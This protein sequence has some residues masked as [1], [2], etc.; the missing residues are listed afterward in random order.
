MAFGSA[1]GL[2]VSPSVKVFPARFSIPLPSPYTR[3]PEVQVAVPAFWS[4]RLP[5]SL[6]P[7]FRV[8]LPLTRRKYGLSNRVSA[9]TSPP[10]MVRV[11]TNAVV[12]TPSGLSKVTP[13]PVTSRLEIVGV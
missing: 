7:P 8:M 9:L 2:P 10:L 3:F 11:S 4:T 13:P 12:A 5:M 1:T 6:L